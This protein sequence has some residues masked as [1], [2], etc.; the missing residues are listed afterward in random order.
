M[1]RKVEIDHITIICPEGT[2]KDMLAIAKQKGI[3]NGIVHRGFGT[4]SKELLDKVPDEANRSKTKD[5]VSLVAATDLAEIFLNKLDEAH[6]FTKEGHGI[7]YA[8]DVDDVYSPRLENLEREV[9]DMADI[10][11]ITAIVKHGTADDLM[12]AA[13]GAGARGGT[14]LESTED[15][16]PELSLFSKDTEGND[17]VVLIIARKDNVSDIITAI[18]QDSLIDETSGMVYV[19]DCH[20]V[21]GLKK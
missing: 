6:D 19:Q 1:P 5:I 2:G 8:V 16:K 4:A 21:H 17:D 9:E 14:L 13:R 18:K 3:I 20:F 15:A 10:Q 11:I 12:K 7:A